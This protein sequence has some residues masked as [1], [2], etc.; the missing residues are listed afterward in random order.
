MSLSMT[1]FALKGINSILGFA[2]QR[3]ANA[4]YLQQLYTDK[5]LN[6]PVA[7]GT[8]TVSGLNPRHAT[9]S[10]GVISASTYNCPIA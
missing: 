9:S 6:N 10:S 2:S 1:F 5:L 8:F 4:Q 3:N 7:A